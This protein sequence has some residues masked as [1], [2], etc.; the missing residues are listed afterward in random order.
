MNES[1][2]PTLDDL[3]DHWPGSSGDRARVELAT[4]RQKA[5]RL[6]LAD[7]E[8]RKL[9]GD[10]RTLEAEISDARS[11]ARL[12]AERACELSARAVEKS[13]HDDVP[14]TRR[15]LAAVIRAARPAIIEEA[16][17]WKKR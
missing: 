5:A 12:A 8:R 17:E 10:I 11:A 15:D 6:L 16:L 14:Q 3:V 1:D 13:Y 7:E 2:K 4:L 9:E